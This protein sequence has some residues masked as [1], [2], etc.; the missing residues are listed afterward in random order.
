MT[1]GRY[2]FAAPVIN[3]SFD[4]ARSEGCWLIQADGRR[5]LDA[6]GGAVVS[7]IGHGRAEVGEAYAKAVTEVSFAVPPFLTPGRERLVDR[8]LDRWVPK[9]LT[10]PFFVSGGSES[11]DAAI[12][13]ARQH[14]VAAGRADRWKV[15]GRDLA[16]HGATL[17]TLAVGGHSNRR[18]LF[19]PLLADHPKAAACYCYRCPFDSTWPECKLE[20]AENLVAVIE[21]EGPETIAA[22]IGEPIGG[23]TAGAIVP[24]DDYWPRIREICDHYDILLIADEVMTGYGRTGKNFGLD[25]WNVVPDILVG[26]KGLAGGYAP[27]GALFAC[28]AVV[29]P[30]IAAGDDLFFFTFSAHSGAV[31]AADVVLDILERENLVE[32]SAVMG[33]VLAQALRAEFAEHPHVGDVRGRGLLQA[34]ELVADRA[35]GEPFP[36]GSG[37]ASKVVVAG[38]ERGAFFYPGGCDP[39]RDAI[40]L[41]PPF[42]ISEDEIAQLVSILS[43]SIDEAVSTL[44]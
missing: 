9:G 23:S 6:A 1:E 20:C 41:G 27:I 36:A 21:S 43:A 14:Q 38:L 37:L 33:E 26:G 29:E 3:A 24:P 8:L 12:R 35:T 31:A 39:A 15:I 30:M 13:L 32:R 17:A 40:V 44:S 7:N 42:I 22:F 18:K 10:R 4:V 34:V 16:Y 5:V 11:V 2:R 19:G 25:H 28:E